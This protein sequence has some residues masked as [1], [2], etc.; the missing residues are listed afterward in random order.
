MTNNPY[1][2]DWRQAWIDRERIRHK[3]DSASYWDG[4]A[5]SF[6]KRSG[7]SNYKD[8]FLEYAQLKPSETVFDMGCGAGTLSI[9]LAQNGHPVIA[10]DFSG[11]MLR[12]LKENAVAAGI[13][14][15]SGV[16]ESEQTVKSGEIC[17]IQTSWE[18]DWGACGINNKIADVA[19][20]S[21]SIAVTDLQP[22]LEKLES[23]AK[24]RVCI[25]LPTGERPRYDE[26]L[27]KY[28]GREL[29]YGGA[30][31]IALNMLFSLGRFP[32][33][34]YIRNEKFDSYES[35]DVAKNAIRES[36][37]E[38]GINEE[39]KLTQFFKEHLKTRT[40]NDGTI[41][42]SRDYPISSSWAFISWDL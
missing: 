21:R 16:A 19:F 3:P 14:A 17:C 9:P 30:H 25:T 38:V 34:R 10:A 18:S 35:E 8:L 26:Q 23:R 5:Q 36:L 41:V 4:R 27:W 15:K 32:E 11:E 24:R 39:E 20:A 7:E 13:T 42:W 29:S 28:L 12:Y 33:L 22:T 2:I 40:K 37:R 31:I 6:N 1:N